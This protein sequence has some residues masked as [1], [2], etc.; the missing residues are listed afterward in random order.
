MNRLL[1][2]IGGFLNKATIYQPSNFIDI[3]HKKREC[4][5]QPDT[6]EGKEYCRENPGHIVP[7]VTHMHIYALNKTQIHMDKMTLN[8]LTAREYMYENHIQTTNKLKNLC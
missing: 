4:R 5:T 3:V 6:T 7:V 2:N 1:P 8:Y